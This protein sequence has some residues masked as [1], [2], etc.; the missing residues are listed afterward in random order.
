MKARLLLLPVFLAALIAAGCGGGGGAAELAPGDIAVVGDAHILKTRFDSLMNQA[1]VNLKIAGQPFP[2]AGTAQYAGFRSQAVTLLVQEAQREA[3]AADLGLTVTDKEIQARLDTI[4]KADP[5]D[6]FGGSEA[7]YQAAL[8]AQGITDADVRASIRSQLIAT[9]LFDNLTKDVTVPNAAIV[10]YYSQHLSEY[11]TP[12][13]REVRYILVGKNKSSLAESLFKQLSGAPDATW[14]A[15]SKKYSQDPG[16]KGTC[17]K[18]SAPFTKGQTV[19][20]FDKL[21]FSL[22]TDKLAKV[23]TKQYGWFVLEPTADIKAG[24][25]TPVEEASK[26]ITD[27]LLKERKDEFMIKWVDDLQKDYCK[28]G[29]INYRVGYKPSPDPCTVTTTSTSTTTTT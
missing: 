29:K 11:Q 27:Q 3:A 24:K 26:K 1:R 2:K 23:N 19:P 17:G 6:G 4:K 10:E 13:T 12:A 7:K 16:S 18:P 9:K 25:T 22:K 5:P 15:L 20:E 14:C 21:A 8:K 28:G